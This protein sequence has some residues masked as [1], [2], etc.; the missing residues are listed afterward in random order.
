MLTVV[1]TALMP[2]FV[3]LGI[4]Y[5]AG[6]KKIVDNWNISSLNVLLMQFLLPITLFISIARTPGSVIRDNAALAIVI[7]LALVVVYLPFLFVER[8][9]FKLAPGD[10]AV[11]TLTSAFPNFASI[12]LPLLTPFFKGEAGLPVAIA[13][14]IGSVTISP[15]TIAL[16]EMAKASQTPD[17]APGAPISVTRAFG[18][19]LINS[20]KKPIFIGPILGLIVSLVGIHLPS[21]FAVA[22]SPLTS[23]TAGVGLFL[24]GF[25]VIGAAHQGG[26]ERGV[27]GRRKERCPACLRRRAG[28]SVQTADQ[29]TG[30]GR[31]APHHSGGILRARL[32]GERRQPASCVGID[33]SSVVDRQHRNAC[34]C[35]PDL[36]ADDR[37]VGVE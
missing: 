8:R 7:A 6:Y 14:A 37:Q 3:G 22:F 34:D 15:L 25:D 19:A 1:I 16:L 11:Q 13:I 12:G 31:P 35:H 28:L 18:H 5:F 33:A 26:R 17:K 32:R 30:R 20:V 29:R 9:I 23:A 27:F 24:T 4:G 21:I 2:V 10:A 36:H